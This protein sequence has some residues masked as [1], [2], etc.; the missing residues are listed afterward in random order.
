MEKIH[1]ITFGNDENNEGFIRFKSSC[2]RF[3]IPFINIGKKV[4]YVDH[5]IK[6]IFLKKYLKTLDPNDVFLFTDAYDLIYIRN[7]EDGLLD[8][9]KKIETQ[10][11]Y[12]TE[13]YF[14]Y[15]LKNKFGRWVEHPKSTGYFKLYKYLNSGIIMGRAGYTFNILNK[16]DISENT[17]CDQSVQAKYFFQNRKDIFLDYNHEISTS[18]SGREGLESR[19]F[20]I[21]NGMLK[22]NNTL[23]FPYIM[24]FPGENTY[25]SEIIRQM[26]PFDLP[27]MKLRNEDKKKYLN[28]RPRKRILNYLKIDNY[29]FN[30]IE[31]FLKYL[32]ILGV[33]IFLA[34][35][36]WNYFGL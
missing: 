19:D 36:G 31:A 23:S 20:M 32:F 11:V 14:H 25:S 28:A 15:I 26:L 9:F 17:E 13:Q 16:L 30:L 18:S 5:G 3:S 4:E 22:N 7:P 29:E 10:L 33:I 35:L 12:S 2:D 27:K 21:Q 6:I 8:I 24:H 34:F 1:Y